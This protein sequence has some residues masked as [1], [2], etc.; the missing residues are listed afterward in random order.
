[1]KCFQ[2]IEPFGV[3]IAGVETEIKAGTIISLPEVKAIPLIETGRIKPT[4]RATYHIY[5]EILQAHLWIV[6]TDRDQQHGLENIPLPATGETLLNPTKPIQ[7][8]PEPVYVSRELKGSA[9]LPRETLLSQNSHQSHSLG[10]VGSSR[11]LTGVSG[12][13]FKVSS[14]EVL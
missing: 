13:I 6:E 1:M 11:D 4:E 8:P 2:V 7:Q 9:E 12:K 3:K 10:L 14:L 5:S